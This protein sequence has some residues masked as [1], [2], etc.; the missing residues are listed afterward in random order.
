MNVNGEGKSYEQNRPIYKRERGLFPSDAL[1]KEV[2]YY[3]IN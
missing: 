3:N 1:V 2:Y